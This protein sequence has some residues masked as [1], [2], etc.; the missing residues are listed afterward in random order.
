[1]DKKTAWSRKQ[2]PTP[3]NDKFAA[4]AQ[5]EPVS[6]IVRGSNINANAEPGEPRHRGTAANKSVW[7]RWQASPQ[8]GAAI[9]TTVDSG[10]KSRVAA[11]VET[12]PGNDF[13]ILAPVDELVK[14]RRTDLLIFRTRANRFYRIAVDGV[15]GA[16]GA[17]QLEYTSGSSLEFVASFA[18]SVIA[19]FVRDSDLYGIES[20]KVTPVDETG[21]EHTPM[22]TYPDGSY[23][24]VLQGLHSYTVTPTHNVYCF[25]PEDNNYSPNTQAPFEHYTGYNCPILSFGG[26][27]IDRISPDGRMLVSGDIDGAVR[28]WK[29]PKG[30]LD[31]TIRRKGA[32]LLAAAFVAGGAEVLVTGADCN[33]ERFEVATGTSRQALPGRE[34]DARYEIAAFSPDGQWLAANGGMRTSVLRQ[35]ADGGEVR[36]LESRVNGVKAI[37]LSPNGRWFATGN[38]DGTMTLW[39]ALAGRV[40]AKLGG[41]AGSIDSLAFHPDA[42]W[43]AWGSRGGKIVIWDL[44]AARELGSWQAH[45]NGVSSLAFTADGGRLVSGSADSS[46]RIWETKSWR[47]TGRLS[48]HPQG[49]TALCVSGQQLI[50]AGVDRSV[51]VWNLATG[52]LMRTLT[53]HEGIVYGVASS[54]KTPAKS[55]WIAS[56]GEDRSVRLWNGETGQLVRVLRGPASAIY[57]LAISPDRTEVM[58]GEA[59][60]EIRAWDM[61]TGAE[62]FHLAGHPGGVNSLCFQGGQEPQWLFSGGEDGSVRVWEA[63][64][65]VLAAT[66]L[67]FRGSHEQANF[68]WLAVTPDGL[69]DGSPTAWKQILWRFKSDP[70]N[71]LPV[72]IFYNDFFQPDVLADLFAGKHPRASADI[73]LRDRRQPRIKLAVSG[74]AQGG[75]MAEG[76]PPQLAQLNAAQPEDAVVVFFAGHGV[77]RESHFY[78]VAH[79]MGYQGGREELDT[80]RIGQITDQGIS[81]VAIGERLESV[82]AGNLL[83]I[84]DAC[85]SGQAVEPDGKASG[86]GPTNSKG[87]AQLAYDKGINILT[88]AQRDQVAIGSFRLGHGLLTYAL[89]EEGVRQMKADNRPPDHQV[90]LREWLDYAADRVP[91]LQEEDFTKTPPERRDL[92]L[93]LDVRRQ[94]PRVFYRREIEAQPLLIAK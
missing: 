57:S 5:I 76:A 39:D 46:I 67:S 92:K 68:D 45:G 72:E 77:A 50:S 18:Y 66:L 11:Y 6:G 91:G 64:T 20:V 79:D 44:D 1:M 3:I 26:I 24:L 81:E 61:A 27:L 59:G 60:G 48:G 29:I 90:L 89:V 2:S 75:V 35:V 21:N 36:M 47:E 15:G 62:R 12:R 49:V 13:S 43:L 52:Q 94:R 4:A 25:D 14:I 38:Q 31:R 10:F 54:A 34:K 58:A 88:A 41:G 86:R 84:I 78:L 32:P 30:K 19:G 73:A 37:A 82:D 8:N 93:E 33:I 51:R 63:K 74:G 55:L 87:L 9:F 40:I 42:P 65:G 23:E 28:L 69:F 71:P 80:E 85:Q 7:Y 53:G 16:S 70:L 17:A 56:A 83:L 22:F